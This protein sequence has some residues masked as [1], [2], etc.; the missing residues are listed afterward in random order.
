MGN[1]SKVSNVYG[2]LNLSGSTVANSY[3]VLELRDNF[4]ATAG[5]AQGQIIGYARTAAFEHMADPDTTFGTADDQYKLNIFDVQMFTVVTL[6]SNKTIAQG[7]LLVGANTGARG[8]IV[9]AITNSDDLILYQVEGT[10][11]KGEMLTLD[12]E[13]LDTIANFHEYK[14][15]LIHI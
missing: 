15:S 10:F 8:Y 5:D 9:D 6:S 12:G 13:S 11:E 2:F 7:S 3:Q 14:L 1:W 4:S